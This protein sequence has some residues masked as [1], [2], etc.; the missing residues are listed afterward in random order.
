MALKLLHAWHLTLVHFPNWQYSLTAMV[1]HLSSKLDPI[2]LPVLKAVMEL[3]QDYLQDGGCT[4]TELC[5]EALKSVTR[6]VRVGWTYWGPATLGN[7]VVVTA[8]LAATLHAATLAFHDT[9][10]PQ[11]FRSLLRSLLDLAEEKYL[12]WR[13]ENND[14]TGVV[15]TCVCSL[16]SEAEPGDLI[17]V[18]DNFPFITSL[19]K[20]ILTAKQDQPKST[21]LEEKGY[22]ITTLLRVSSPFSLTVLSLSIVQLSGPTP[23]PYLSLISSWVCTVMHSGSI[24]LEADKIHLME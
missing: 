20:D 5:V 23:H 18:V 10:T 17:W 11:L 8:T 4:E 9:L 21:M 24:I 14:L 6:I 22:I 1:R 2:A 3:M 7:L 13:K 16:L 15:V 12:P 19:M